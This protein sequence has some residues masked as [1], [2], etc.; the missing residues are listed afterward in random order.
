MSQILNIGR[1]LQSDYWEWLSACA[2]SGLEAYTGALAASHHPITAP[3]EEDVAHILAT[4]QRLGNFLGSVFLPDQ[5]EALESDTAAYPEQQ[6]TT[7]G[8]DQNRQASAS[9]AG[10]WNVGAETPFAEKQPAR[11][12]HGEGEHEPPR[13]ATTAHGASLVSSSKQPKEQTPALL[14]DAFGSNRFFSET[15]TPGPKQDTDHAETGSRGNTKQG[16]SA[17]PNQMAAQT[18]N[19]VEPN[20]FFSNSD[21]DRETTPTDAGSGTQKTVQGTVAKGAGMLPQ[22][23]PSDDFVPLKRLSHFAD[24]FSGWVSTDPLP[25]LNTV[26]ADLQSNTDFVSTSIFPASKAIYPESTTEGA[27][28]QTSI[29][30][31]TQPPS[32]VRAGTS[33]H[34][35]ALAQTTQADTPAPET[36]LQTTK[37]LENHAV[38]NP[39]MDDLM[40]LF[41]RRMEQAFHRFYG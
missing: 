36:G 16:P 1:S 38:S 7:D 23:E 12:K 2:E 39:D 21:W 33:E 41:A 28:S 14:P 18:P 25:V 22:N 29:P 3:L 35:L 15:Q 4:E 20:G 31:S 10:R 34:P 5:S 30:Y 9:D 26:P 40:E 13:T 24:R 27:P 11:A 6:K 17:A 19:A 8:R 37:N 32:N